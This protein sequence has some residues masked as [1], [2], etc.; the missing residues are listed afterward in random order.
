MP[1]N[2]G[3]A[4]PSANIRVFGVLDTENLAQGIVFCSCNPDQPVEIPYRLSDMAV[5]QVYC[6]RCSRKVSIGQSLD[7][8]KDLNMAEA[9]TSI[10]GPVAP[11]LA[12][13]P[14]LFRL[15]I[16]TL[17]ISGICFGIYTLFRDLPVVGEVMGHLGLGPAPLGPGTGQTVTLPLTKAQFAK[18]GM[19]LAAGPTGPVP[20]LVALHPDLFRGPTAPQLHITLAAI[21]DL[22]QQTDIKNALVTAQVWQQAL[23]DQNVSQAD[24]RHAA[25]EQ[26]I[27]QLQEKLYPQQTPAPP[28]VLARF[29]ELLGLLRTA[30]AQARLEGT[31]KLIREAEGLLE[32]HPQDLAPFSQSFFALKRRYNEIEG[33]VNGIARIEKHLDQAAEFARKGKATEALEHETKAKSLSSRTPMTKEVGDRFD[34]R[35]RDLAPD[36]L[37]VRGQQAVTELRQCLR[38]GDQEARD[39]LVREARTCLPGLPDSKVGALVKETETAA[40]M[41]VMGQKGSSFAKEVMF[42]LQYE[43]ALHCYATDDGPGFLS[44]AAKAAALSPTGDGT[45]KL[46]ML[47]FD[48]LDNFAGDTLT[49]NEEAP[50][51]PERFGKLRTLLDAAGP[52]KEDPRWVKLDA[53]LRQRGEQVARKS[54]AKAQGLAA[55][56]QLAAARQAVKNAWLLGDR[57]TVLQARNLDQQ[58]DQELKARTDRAIEQAHWQRIQQLHQDRK[59]LETWSELTNYAK[60]YP[61]SS[62]QKEVTKLQ[63]SLRGAIPPLLAAKIR[64][65]DNYRDKKMWREFYEGYEILKSLPWTEN[66]TAKM[67]LFGKFIED[68]KRE[69]NGRFL[70]LASRHGKMVNK[71]EVVALLAELPRLIAFS[72]ELAEAN[73]LLEEAKQKGQLYAKHLLSTLGGI[74]PQLAAMRL[75][76]IEILD[77]N[78]PIAAE[79]RRLVKKR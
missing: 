9:E 28:T 22:G 76:E 45:K 18:L 67:K 6:P 64:D 48:F 11:R 3:P 33:E 42:R 61:Q 63:E 47:V 32:K 51:L 16:G 36:L 44:Q 54:L 78:G 69:A 52:W 58:W 53:P 55:K 27:K 68:N 77:C 19:F 37:F 40:A 20:T 38:E 57:P 31:D 7:K 62:R 71:E 65:L 60:R 49:L 15:L 14:T 2:A 66:E 13:G 1:P 70:R 4:K 56:D 72:P 79:A 24:P 39:L 29:R 59:T 17:V 41:P 34:K 43:Q 75:R 21:Q 26:V 23:R 5:G 10:P 46:A 25:L 35:V 74:S 8:V 73:A 50:E 12:W 30:I